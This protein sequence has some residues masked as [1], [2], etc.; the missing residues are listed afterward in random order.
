MASPQTKPLVSLIEAVRAGAQEMRRIAERTNREFEL[1]ASLRSVLDQLYREGPQ[2][3]PAMARAFGKTR[4]H[5]QQCVDRLGD[6]GF[7][8]ARANPAH[9]RSSLIALT[10]DGTRLMSEI[11]RHEKA[12]L[13]R[14][15]A[16]LQGEPVNAAAA[17][18]NR[19]LAALSA[20]QR[21]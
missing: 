10:P 1:S 5:V 3:V 8:S 17:V 12:I 6:R 2:T 13:E 7:V 11:G 9:R 15:E 16:E 18:L 4:Q 14:L 20:A 19:F 21:S